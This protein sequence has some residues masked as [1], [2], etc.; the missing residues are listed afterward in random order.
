MPPN[1]KARR[2][3]GNLAAGLQKS[4]LLG[5][6]DTFPIVRNLRQRNA[7]PARK[8]AASPRASRAFEALNFRHCERN[9]LRGFFDLRLPSGLILRGA[10]LH[11]KDGKHWVGLP[12]RSYAG[13]DGG[14]KWAALVDF[15]SAKR[16]KRFQ[17]L[18]TEAVLSAY[19]QIGRRA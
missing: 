13:A 10:S 17:E 19:E 3:D 9:T 18:A 16:R 15:A 4:S 6:S 11:W 12:A 8:A 7:N 5:G 14:Q 1:A 2:G